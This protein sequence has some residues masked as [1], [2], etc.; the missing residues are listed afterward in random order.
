MPV[1]VLACLLCLALLLP[2][3]RAQV[4]LG[5]SAA[6]ERSRWQEVDGQRA[7]LVDEQG[8]L[9]GG[10]LVLG[11]RC[12]V[13]DWQAEWVR[14]GGSRAYEGVSSTGVPLRT[15]SEVRRQA[16]G[17]TGWL[18][19][20]E[21]WS[22]GA[23][24][25]ARRLQRDI[26]GVGAALGY[27]EQFDDW[28]GGAGARYALWRGTASA[29]TAEAWLGGGPGGRL[30][31][32]LPRADPTVLSLGSSRLAELGLTWLADLTET[33]PAPGWQGWLRLLHRRERFAAGPAS[34]V[35]RNGV[36]VGVAAQPETHQT[37]SGLQLG[38]RYR[39]GG[40]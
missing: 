39:F 20:G 1:E 14:L 37:S 38:L 28:Q 32:M 26:A 19:V 25:A 10:S 11:C 8:D 30:T 3:A 22:A 12:A 2:A 9:R 27:P 24:I 13:V 21:R 33:A 31:L 40:W 36:I 7:P 23:R 4:W 5:A 15:R 6:A 18:P 34:A 35:L 29:L 17:I 16:V